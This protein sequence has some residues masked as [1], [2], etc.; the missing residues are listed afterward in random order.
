MRVLHLSRPAAGGVLRFLQHVV[1]RLEQA[2]VECVVACPAEMHSTLSSVRTLH[3]GVSD[4]PR[5]LADLRC[6]LQAQSWQK[7]YD[8]FHAHGLRAVSVLALT[9]P[10]RWVFTLHNLPPMHL[11]PLARWLLRRAART[12]GR[13]LSVSQAVQEG[14]LRHFPQSAP[15]CEVVPGG[16]DVQMIRYSP[17][18]RRIARQQWGLPEEAPVALC[19]ARLM[20]DKGVDIL[21]RALAEAPTWYALIVGEGPQRQELVHL[22]SVLRVGER[23]RFT[24]YLP[25]LDAAW[26]ACDVAVVPSRREGL[27]LFALE[28]MAAQKPV[29]ASQTGG[30]AE[31]VLP[32][33]MGWL[34]PP[35]DP[36]AL[37][38]ALQEAL[39][40]R[41]RWSAMGERGKQHVLQHY[42]WEHTAQRLL[43]VYRSLVNR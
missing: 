21:L 4:R 9:P 29:V 7:D 15:K 16:V 28:A 36:G 20:K 25:T 10:L 31:V 38:A 35:D 40:Q 42:T 13:I 5:P 18:D 11:P 24:G 26:A 3:W 8:L 27:G 32:E 17:T 30:L 34:V 33:E 23:V 22:T 2:G 43:E 6:A 39:A 19:V 37:A 14:W 41:E 12:A 1:P